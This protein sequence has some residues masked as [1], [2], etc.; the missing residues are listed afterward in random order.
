VQWELTANGYTDI[1]VFV[2]GGITPN[3]IRDLRNVAD[4]F[5]V[6]GYISKAAPIDF[7]LDIVEVDGKPATKRGKISGE[8][9]VY[10]T[11]DGSHHVGLSSHDTPSDGE[12]LLE[13]L[14]R[15]GEIVRDFNFDAAIERVQTEV[16]QTR[17][18]S[19]TE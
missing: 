7:A 6:G 2:S 17:F 12:P 8:K 13:P 5:G 3:S 16:S 1:D 9:Q 15:D 18:A 11:D 14:I 4:G 19:R 10:R